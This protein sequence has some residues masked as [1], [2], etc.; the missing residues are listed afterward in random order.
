[1][2][3]NKFSWQPIETAPKGENLRLRVINSA[4]EEYDLTF[5]CI[6]TAKGF[7]TPKGTVL[8][9]LPTQWMSFVTRTP[10]LN[11]RYSPPVQP[12]A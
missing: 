6:R 10:R 7:V 5:P 2:H 8:Q 1:M 3:I 11:P 9:V 4:G 12:V